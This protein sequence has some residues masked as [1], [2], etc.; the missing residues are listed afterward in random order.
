MTVVRSQ[1]PP[2]QTGTPF[3]NLVNQDAFNTLLW[4]KGYDVLLEEAIRC[5]C[6]GISS[7][8]KPSC[9][10]CLGMGW[11][12]VNP[13]K[14][15]AII[16]SINKVTQYKDWSEEMRG[17]AA[18]TF[19]NADRIGF[20]DKV[21][22][23]NNYSTFSEILEVRTVGVTPNVKKIVFCSYQPHAIKSIFMYAGSSTKLRKLLTT[24]Y[25][26]STTNPYVIELNLSSYPTGYNQC[27]SISYSHH[28]SY[29]VLDLPHDVR[30]T[31]EQ[32]NNGFKEK[33]DMPIQT[34]ARKSHFMI[35]IPTAYD[36]NNLLD[37]SWL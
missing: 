21:T 36:S 35:G 28:I 32:N 2:S 31:V 4:Q 1:T 13:I 19:M 24:E 18:M 15:K 22:F 30:I 11:V 6:K 26:I 7:D 25:S 3:V 20:M 33:R 14:T 23:S 37:N 12:F 10:N 9:L 27:I 34:I 17:T 16:T 29:N 8:G 5:P